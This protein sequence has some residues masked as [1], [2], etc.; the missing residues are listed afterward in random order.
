MKGGYLE[1]EVLFA[2]F[3]AGEVGPLGSF[4]QKIMIDAK[5]ISFGCRLARLYCLLDNVP[6][7]LE[8]RKPVVRLHL[9]AG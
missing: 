1:I 9:R 3:E 5:L 6:T 2:M 8:K 7:E 4:K